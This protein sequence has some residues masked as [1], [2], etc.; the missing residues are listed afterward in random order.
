MYQTLIGLSNPSPPKPPLVDLSLLL[1]CFHQESFLVPALFFAQSAPVDQFWFLRFVHPHYNRGCVCYLAVSLGGHEQLV[2][3]G[4]C[5]LDQ[6][7][8]F[9]FV[10]SFTCLPTLY[11]Q[12]EPR[13]KVAHA[14]V[15]FHPPVNFSQ[16]NSLYWVHSRPTCAS[17]L[18]LP[19]PFASDAPHLCKH[20]LVL[21][22]AFVVQNAIVHKTDCCVLC[23]M[24]I[25]L[26]CHANPQLV[27]SD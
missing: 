26:A 24:L 27:Y 2:P 18:A 20:C 23:P 13:P 8:I 15:F 1:C 14:I 17:C 22:L 19:K 5:C 10:S 16:R 3:Q 21:Y 25:H 11:L 4:S 9:L 7:H 12:Y 6:A